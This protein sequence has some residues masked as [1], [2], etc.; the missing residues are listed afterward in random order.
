MDTRKIPPIVTLSAA[1]CASIVTYIR[2]YELRE[3][4]LIILV[5]IIG[6]YIFSCIIKFIFDKCGLSIEAIRQRE[7]EKEEAEKAAQAE[8][9]ARLE[10]ERLANLENEDGS[11]REK[12]T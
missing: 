10:A 11:V 7:K 8:E 5:V 4:L 2:H 6:F 3:A 12:D 1:L 9:E